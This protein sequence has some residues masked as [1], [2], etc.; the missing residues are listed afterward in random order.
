MLTGVTLTGGCTVICTL[1]LTTT[2]TM[3]EYCVT[4]VDM[5][6]KTSL[7]ILAL[8]WIFMS[9]F[10]P[11]DKFSHPDLVG[12]IVW[13]DCELRWINDRLKKEHEQR[14]KLEEKIEILEL[15]IAQME[16]Y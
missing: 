15:K 14:C 5:L 11:V 6:V 7:L 13:A 1:Q 3:F 9:E 4:L 10:T 16:T 12:G 2:S 8:G